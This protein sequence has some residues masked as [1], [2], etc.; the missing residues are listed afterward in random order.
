MEYEVYTEMPLGSSLVPTKTG[1]QVVAFA[2]AFA[3][4][5]ALVAALEAVA[6]AVDITAEA[7]EAYTNA[8]T[9]TAAAKGFNSVSDSLEVVPKCSVVATEAAIVVMEVDV[10]VVGTFVMVCFADATMDPKDSIGR[11]EVEAMVPVRTGANSIAIGR[12]RGGLVIVRLVEA[13]RAIRA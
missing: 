5:L 6:S 10:D 13:D 12:P 8:E 7:K 11:A 9:S 2:T 3:T 1:N 4:V